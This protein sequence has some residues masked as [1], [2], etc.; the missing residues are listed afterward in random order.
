MERNTLYGY[1]VI[2]QL[3]LKL[4]KRIF[5][6]IDPLQCIAIYCIQNQA[7]KVAENVISTTVAME[8]Y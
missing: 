1:L 6:L 2:K 5:W 4:W 7:E 8:L 3:L